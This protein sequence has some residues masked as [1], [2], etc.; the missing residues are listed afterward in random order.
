M[1]E[2]ITINTQS[3]IRIEWDKIIYFDPYKINT[4]FHDADYIFIT[5]DHYDH[6]DIDSINNIL[7]EDTKIIIPDSMASSVLGIFP[8]KNIIGV[9]PNEIY[10]IDNINIETIPSYN[11]NKEYHPIS[12]KWVGYII[13]LDDKR[14]YISGDTDITPENTKVKSDI[15]LI[16]IG[17]KFTMNY[18]E[19]AELTN[20]IKPQIV[21]PTH[22]GS[23]VG[24]KEDFDK[25][26]SL[27]DNNI[28]CIDLLK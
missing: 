28:T 24:T 14:L 19:A 9:L 13:S 7:K 21:I 6:Y 3:S 4:A 22:Y 15:I 12:K 16:P 8:S 2:K 5:H 1:I 18:K 23:I 27:L 26:I 25:F 20:I 17:G 10:Q 11:I